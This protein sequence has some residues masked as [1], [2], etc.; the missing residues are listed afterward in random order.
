M[1]DITIYEQRLDALKIYMDIC[2]DESICIKEWWCVF[3][4]TGN[5]IR[6]EDW[7]PSF[8]EWYYMWF[9]VFYRPVQDD[10]QN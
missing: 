6:R 9:L 3:N 8:E 5:I 2:I 7:L 10:Y 4:D 1:I